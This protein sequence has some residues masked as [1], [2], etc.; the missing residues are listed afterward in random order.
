[1]KTPGPGEPTALAAHGLTRPGWKLHS[2]VL[3]REEIKVERPNVSDTHVERGK[4]L[5]PSLLGQARQRGMQ[6]AGGIG[7]KIKHTTYKPLFQ[8]VL[9]NH[10][11][12]LVYKEDDSF[13]PAQHK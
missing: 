8:T 1:M 10:F 3:Q 11:S 6:V 2:H 4:Q 13:I 12:L 9:P 5:K 7:T